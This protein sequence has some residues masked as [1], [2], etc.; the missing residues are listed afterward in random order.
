MM[1]IKT[2]DFIVSAISQAVNQVIKNYDWTMPDSLNYFLTNNRQDYEKACLECGQSK[3]DDIM[4]QVVIMLEGEFDTNDDNVMYD[5]ST[6]VEEA[7][8]SAVFENMT[9]VFCVEKVT[10]IKEKCYVVAHS[11]QDAMACFNRCV[12]S[13]DLKPTLQQETI[14][15]P[16]MV[17]ALNDVET[18]NIGALMQ[19]GTLIEGNN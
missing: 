12:D 11:P 10:V 3:F 18:K 7:I 4:S 15:M 13:D 5:I 9:D 14:E 19:V 1:K 16:P 6:V 2:N 17:R 8:N